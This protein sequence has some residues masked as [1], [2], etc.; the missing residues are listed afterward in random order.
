MATKPKAVLFV[1]L[2]TITTAFGQIFFKIGSDT[3]FSSAI[4]ALL[5]FDLFNPLLKPLYLLI[6]GLFLY[7]IGAGLLILALRY[8]ELSVIYPIFA[9]NYIWVTLLSSK[10]F[11]EEIYLLKIIGI[12]AIVSG[13]ALIGIGSRNK[14]WNNEKATKPNKINKS[15]QHGENK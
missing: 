3:N 10:Y 8:G 5:S 14:T 6:F 13:I 11:G 1:L 9:T 7:G 2:C 12:F 4:N 15:K